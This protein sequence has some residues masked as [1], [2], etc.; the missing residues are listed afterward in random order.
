MVRDLQAA[1]EKK[2]L[3]QK[4]EKKDLE[5]K[6]KKSG[7]GQQIENLQPDIRASLQNE[8]APEIRS[9]AL[10]QENLGCIFLPRPGVEGQ[11]GGVCP[12]TLVAVFAGTK[13][14]R[15]KNTA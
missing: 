8:T 11:W 4:M 6:I 3:E 7:L 12:P 1:L 13:T 14:H 15:L 10:S 5:Q 2:D 9:G